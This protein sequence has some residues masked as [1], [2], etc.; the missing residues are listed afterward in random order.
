MGKA[1]KKKKEL[2]SEMLKKQNLKITTY[3]VSYRKV[4]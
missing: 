2:K 3:M 4:L 1:Q